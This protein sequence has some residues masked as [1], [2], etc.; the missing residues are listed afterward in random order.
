MNFLL[1]IL[2][3]LIKMINCSDISEDRDPRINGYEIIPE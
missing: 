1:I 3:I 2:T